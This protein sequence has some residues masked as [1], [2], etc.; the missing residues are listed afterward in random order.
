[1]ASACGS[2]RGLLERPGVRNATVWTVMAVIVGVCAGVLRPAFVAEAQEPSTA[3]PPKNDYTDQKNW[4]CRP[5]RH[6]ACTVDLTA[7]VI[8]ADGKLAR[9]TWMSNPTA[10]IDC[11]YVYPTVSHDSTLNSSM[12]AGP[13]EVNIA[14]MQF[15]RFGSKCR[16][17]A[18]L[19]RQLTVAALRALS[20]GRSMSANDDLA[21]G[22][23]LDAWK[24]YLV[25]DNGGR[26]VVLIG[27]SQGSGWLMQLIKN[28]IDGKPMQSRLVS[29]LLLGGDVPVPK[30]K[31]VGGAF[32]HIPLCRAVRQTGCVLAYS[33]FRATACPRLQGEGG[34]R[35]RPERRHARRAVET[36]RRA[37][38]P[39]HRMEGP[40]HRRRRGGFRGGRSAHGAAS[41]CETL[42][43]KIGQLAL[44]NDF[45]EHALGKAGL[46]SAKR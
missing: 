23:V 10:P 45:L 6:D 8:T 35:G 39:D 28:E 18:P 25:H 14:R 32:Q 30:G 22:D 11:F 34:P 43:A 19:Y 31:D 4:L 17:F 33:S 42:H 16:L 7:T 3:T 40:A 9:E 41:R 29:A 46:L 20:A 24:A 26:G 15:A 1:M 36:L 44:E 13:E 21:Y 38:R 12:T 37:S 27:H 5:G 2:A